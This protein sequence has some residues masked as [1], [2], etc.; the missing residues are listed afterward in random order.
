[1][2]S[3]ERGV[4]GACAPSVLRTGAR[5]ACMVVL[6]T[7]HVA[8]A[9]DVSPAPFAPSWDARP[10]QPIE[11]AALPDSG[12][13]LT[14]DAASE[15]DEERAYP[16][17]LARRMAGRFSLDLNLGLSGL[18]HEPA[19]G[20]I[21]TAMILL[22]YR[23]HLYPKLGFHLRGGALL[24]IPMMITLSSDRGPYSNDPNMVTTRMMG[25]TFEGVGFFSP[26]GRFYVGPAVSLDYVRFRDTTLRMDDETAHLTNG[27]YIGWGCDVG[28]TFGKLE[29]INIYQSLR[30]T[31]TSGESMIFLLFGI[32]YLL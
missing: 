25:A 23:K 7:T 26:N 28:G 1:M 30:M 18:K 5:I 32:G 31:Y 14:M 19:T 2:Q 15:S 6:A 16:L 24:G 3:S 4:C 12:A 13:P 21:P 20:F 11:P 10:E 9:Q 27:P 29:Q 22:G 8:L 17:L